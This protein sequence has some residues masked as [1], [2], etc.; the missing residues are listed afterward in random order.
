MRDYCSTYWKL[1]DRFR[2][3]PGGNE[4]HH[5]YPRWL[6][7]NNDE[8]VFVN[9]TQHACLHYLVWLEHPTHAAASSFLAAATGWRRGVYNCSQVSKKLITNVAS[10]NLAEIVKNT[11]KEVFIERGKK[12]GKQ[13]FANKKG[14]HSPDWTYE[15]RLRSG[16]KGV[17][18]QLDAGKPARAMT[19][20]ITD[21]NGNEFIVYNR[22][23]F[24]RSLGLRHPKQLKQIG[25]KSRPVN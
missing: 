16:R 25:Y 14:I 2:K 9:Q 5:V 21:N 17:K 4:K 19:W 7:H 3:T 8:V 12:A 6:G 11:P 1:I 24:L 20:V 23:E 13:N 22:A 18:K 10:V 15:D